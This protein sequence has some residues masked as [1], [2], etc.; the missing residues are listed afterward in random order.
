MKKV[1]KVMCMVL[2]IIIMSL[3][4]G[5]GKEVTTG[6]SGSYSSSLNANPD[7]V[8][9]IA[10]VWTKTGFANH[11]HGG[12]DSGPMIIFG[13]EG[14]VQYIRTTDEF[15][16]LLAEDIIHNDNGTTIVKIRD[17]AKWHNGDPVV[18]ID[19]LSYY[20]LNTTDLTRYLYNMEVIDDNNNR[21]L[22]D[23]KTLKLTWKPWREPTD[24][25]KTMLMAQ[26]TK[27]ASVQYKEFKPYVDYLIDLVDSIPTR[28]TEDNDKGETRFGKVLGSKSQL[29]Y[30]KYNE[31]RAH[32]PDWYVATGAYKLDSYNENQMVLIKNQDYYLK[33][34]V[35]FERIEAKQ[36]SNTNQIFA[37]L[38]SATLDYQ[39]GTL[40]RDITASILKSN[41]NMVSYK[42]YDQGTVGLYFNLEKK[43]WSD[44]RV[45]EAFQYIFDRD[46]IK[47]AGNPYGITSWKPMMVMSPVEAEQYLDVDVFREIAEYSYDQNKTEQLLKEVGWE[48][49]DGKWYDAN[50]VKVTITIGF[51]DIFSKPAQSAKAQLDRFGI[52]VTIKNGG[53]WTTWYG[54]ARL[55][56]SPYDCVVAFT[57]L[58]PYGSHP[59]GSMKHFFD[60]LQAHVLHLQMNQKGTSTPTDDEIALEVDLLNGTGKVR[61]M[62]LYREI[63]IYEDQQLKDVT[64]AIV[65]GFSQLNYG[66]HFY[67]NV[68]GSFFDLSK[69]GGL[70]LESRFAVSRDITYIPKP[71]DDD[72]VPVA[73][74]NIF[75][76]QAGP[77]IRGEIY[78]RP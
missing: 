29:L 34:Q 22:D 59:G 66:V 31:F 69:V 14:L 11:F 55:E 28:V 2:A 40:P 57:E 39:D 43:L 10:G 74:L 19:I 26:D 51:Q 45:R 50:N 13:I 44:D 73:K 62:D 68:T 24:Y 27:S 23:D 76:T 63:Y 75:F 46:E 71:N 4:A 15:Y 18:A 36:Y 70:P 30:D 5:C 17:N 53:D 37:D 32:R 65:L 33:D 1:I 6:Y 61:V 56:N 25:A 9:R 47:E 12:G 7:K 49:I 20:V 3:L 42:F 77:Y 64:G 41:S 78:P 16:Y 67:E 60:T 72:F 48:K 35:G 54:T 8:L 21:K 52:D 38:S 58:N